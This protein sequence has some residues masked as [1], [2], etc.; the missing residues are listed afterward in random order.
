MEMDDYVA[1][2][3]LQWYER[4]ERGIMDFAKHVPLT[5]QNEDIQAP[6]LAT[7]LTDACSLID[8]VFR[9]MTSESVIVNGKDKKRDDCKI[10]DFAQLYSAKLDLPNTRSI[11]LVS[12]PRSK[13]PFKAWDGL[14]AGGEHIP[15][16]WWQIYNDLKHDCL[17][18]LD[19]A[20]LGVTLDSI[21]ALHQVLC[22]RIDM[23]P[24]LMRRGWFPTGNYNVNFVL[25]EVAKGL[26]PDAFV[27]QT[28]LFAVPVGKV[29]GGT[30]QESQFPENVKDLKLWHFSC[31]PNLL[32][33]L[34]DCL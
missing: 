27:V 31:K 19:K 29:R 8:S 7:I 20:T 1:D 15:L 21:C 28:N 17:L 18:N 32:E 26:L 9:N 33:F 22:R 6:S 13:N 2:Q 24:N 3:V 23:I 11:M 4:L 12:P 25:Q 30:P 14:T 16:S 34:P 10:P 5:S